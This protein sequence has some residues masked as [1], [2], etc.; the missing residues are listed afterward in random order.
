MIK[1]SHLRSVVIGRLGGSVR[2]ERSGK[3]LQGV[4]FK[5]RAEGLEGA[6]G[7]SREVLSECRGPWAGAL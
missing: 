5:R 7:E 2:S 6:T 4:M 3:T 1:R